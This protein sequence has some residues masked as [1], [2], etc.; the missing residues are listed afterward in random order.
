MMDLLQCLRLLYHLITLR[1]GHSFCAHCCDNLF[2]AKHAKC[3]TYESLFS[4]LLFCS[5]S[6]SEY[7]S[8]GVQ[9]GAGASCRLIYRRAP[10]STPFVA[11]VPLKIDRLACRP[12]SRCRRVLP[13]HAQG[14]DICVSVSLARS[15]EQAF[16]REYRS[17][18]DEVF[19]ERG[20]AEAVGAHALLTDAS[21]GRVDGG[22]VLM[23]GTLCS[24]FSIWTL[25]FQRSACGSLFSS[26]AIA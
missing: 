8:T 15:L 19:A 7:R 17:R 5:S 9:A 1:C 24:P 12:T 10:E 14:A 21:T 6:T 4:I 11:V 23:A 18:R 2:K 13:L 26:L 3:P 25:C 22:D 20:A 16:P